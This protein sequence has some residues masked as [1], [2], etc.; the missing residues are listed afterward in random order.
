MSVFN[1]SGEKKDPAEGTAYQ[2]L[3]VGGRAPEQVPSLVSLAT[4]S[5]KEAVMPE[6]LVQ[7]LSL[8]ELLRKARRNAER[9]FSH[10]VTQ[11]AHQLEE[12]KSSPEMEEIACVASWIEPKGRSR[13]NNTQLSKVL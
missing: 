8:M 4:N 10:L 6:L 5:A 1:P 11:T 9:S 3:G 7:E 12:L 13:Q 2:M